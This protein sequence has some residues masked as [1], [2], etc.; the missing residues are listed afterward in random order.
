MTPVRAAQCWSSLAQV[1][2]FLL[3]KKTFCNLK[4]KN[5]EF[6]FRF[7]WM[8]KLRPGDVIKACSQGHSEQSER[9]SS[10]ACP[11]LLWCSLAELPST[12]PAVE[13]RRDH[14]EWVSAIA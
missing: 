12:R 8:A 7:L 1:E 13:G 6:N 4:K 9:E 2:G 3:G 10:P 11:P 5:K 14:R